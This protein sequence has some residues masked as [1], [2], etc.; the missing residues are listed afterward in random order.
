MTSWIDDDIV[1]HVGLHKTGT[2]WLQ[3]HLFVASRGYWNPESAV[4][5]PVKEFVRPLIMDERGR[6]IPDEAFDPS[7]IRRALSGYN[8][9]QGLVAIASS[10]RLGGHPFSNGVDRRQ[11]ALRVKAVFPRTKILVVIREQ[12]AA[13]M[14]NY[15]QYLKYGGWHTPE[16]FLNGDAD[17]RQP[18]LTLHFW[19]FARLVELYQGLFT[20]ERVLVLPYEMFRRE[21]GEFLRRISRFSGAPEGD[22]FPTEKVENPRRARNATAYWT[23]RMTCLSHPSSAN[24]FFC[25]PLGRLGALLD[26]S[27]KGV[28]DAILPTVIDQRVTRMLESRINAAIGNTYAESNRRASS[29]IGVDLSAYGYRVS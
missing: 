14:S 8:K 20:P 3:R 13:V 5:C 23:R 16:R 11:L 25:S 15:M 29:L 21:P 24:A 12:G 18:T 9:P 26:S 2:T 27:G 22:D 17:S 1:V 7:D 10:E 19:D 4:E 6:L 28:L